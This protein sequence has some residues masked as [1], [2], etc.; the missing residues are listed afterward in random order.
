M[1]SRV[2]FHLD[3][4]VDSTISRALRGY[5]V[6]V[7]T[8]VEAGLRTATDQQQMAYAVRERRVLITHDADFLRLTAYHEDHP[9][10]AF[11]DRSKRSVGDIIRSLL[12]IY[13]VLA[14]EEMVG[15]V[16]F[17]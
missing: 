8:T 4:H 3:E 2:R 13:E 10:I 17:L 15:R 7:T 6:D 12:L 5:G 14:P 16:E 1:P 11:C 9:G